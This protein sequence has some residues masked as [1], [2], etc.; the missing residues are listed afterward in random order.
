MVKTLP[1]VDV[2]TVGLGW[3]GGIIAAECAKAGLKVI[4]LERGQERGTEDFSKVHDEYRYAIRYELMQNLAKETI[5]FRNN[6][7]MP[8][9]P[10]RQMG[11][12]LLGEGLGGS[13]THWNGQTW[14]F[15][16]YDFQIKT[17]TDKKYGPNKLSEDYILQ[18]WGLTYDQLEPYFDKFEKTAGISG[19]DN[20]PNWGKRSA[21][22][23]TPPMKKTQILKKF[24][25]ATSKLG[26]HPFMMPSANLSEFYT[27]PDGA[28]ITACQ[29]CGF[30]ERFGCEYG[31]KTSPE[32]TVVPTA[33][34]TGNFEMKFQ[35]NVVEV[36]KSGDKVSGVRYVDTL[37]GEEFIQPA[38]V[39]VLTSYV[40]NNTKL[41]MVSKIGEQYN[42]DTGKGTLGRNY[43]YQI[44]PGATGFFD[45]QYNT[46][47]GAGALGMAIDD[48]NG[49]SFDHSNLGFIHGGNIS[50]TQTGSRPIA[51]N[52]APPD[53]P[54]WGAE[55]KKQSIHNFTRT[56]SV[57]AQ[58]A[59]ISHKENYLSLDGTYKDAYGVPLLQ[60][61]YNFTKQDIA[62]HKF[63]SEKSAEIMK[64]MGAKTVVSRGEIDQYDIVPYQTT[65]NTG[66]TV[67]SVAP[68]EGVVNNYLQHWNAEN[69]FVVGAGNFAHNG[70]YNPTG[71]VGALAYRAAEGII[72]YSKSSG[73]LV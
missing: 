47:M 45:E 50:I 7:K 3:T 51:T 25:S 37:S 34:K 23:P 33:R 69:L 65:H 43:C 49:D 55:F 60:L 73:S 48:F 38:E 53:T 32:I 28:Q 5:T 40:F 54:T 8:A 66:G 15:L 18:D 36:L 9:L 19:E 71:T 67:M 57:G 31:A 24:E 13:G 61:T 64:E 44:L 14:R 46:F 41:L 52:V 27:N 20:N 26:Y 29:Y 72:K 39:V 2:V 6:R 16:P 11:S 58:G 22:Y 10:M 21:D 42:P 68:E 63:I 62:L 1:K 70:G 56:L 4:G 17:M 12:F 35:A 59:S 30:C